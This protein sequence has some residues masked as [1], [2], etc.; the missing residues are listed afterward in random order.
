MGYSPGPMDGYYHLLR[1][2]EELEDNTLTRCPSVYH[3]RWRKP[4]ATRCN[5]YLLKHVQSESQCSSLK[6]KPFKHASISKHR[7]A[8]W[9]LE[10]WQPQAVTSLSQDMGC[11]DAPG[12]LGQRHSFWS[13][14]LCGLYRTAL[15]LGYIGWSSYKS[16]LRKSPLNSH[17]I[18]GDQSRE[19]ET[20]ASMTKCELSTWLD[21]NNCCC[22]FSKGF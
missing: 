8:D 14:T 15:F 19:N 16:S 12:L 3:R 13:P 11:I 17:L 5:L 20:E 2:R 1:H 7:G 4:H 18:Q 22:N 6:S 9:H 21:K 10:T